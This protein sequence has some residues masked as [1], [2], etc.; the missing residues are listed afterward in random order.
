[1]LPGEPGHEGVGI[2][3]EKGTDVKEFN[4]G[5]IVGIK[6]FG[7]YGIVIEKTLCSDGIKYTVRWRNNERDLPKDSF[8]QWELYRP[9]LN[10]LPS[11]ILK[12]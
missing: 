3:I 10:S 8:Y 12:Y 11:V 6:Y 7:I 5:D 2:I 9:D 4:E 1:M